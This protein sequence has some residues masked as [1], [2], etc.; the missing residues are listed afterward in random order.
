LD[1]SRYTHGP[2]LQEIDPDATL[3][4]H[5]GREFRIQGMTIG[6][7]QPGQHVVEDRDKGG[8]FQQVVE[9]Q[10]KSLRRGLESGR[11]RVVEIIVGQKGY[12]QV[13]V[14]I[15]STFE[16]LHEGFRDELI[17]RQIQKVY[18][19]LGILDDL[20]A[21]LWSQLGV[22]DG[23]HPRIVVTLPVNGPGSQ[24][25]DETDHAFRRIDAVGPG[26]KIP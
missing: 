9:S 12:E 20:H 22:A 10:N 26:V 5:K 13:E 1:G 8:F 14:G 7:L 4:G 25:E 6:P 15:V 21:E 2:A 11:Y 16:E 23:D 19:P 24:A 18:L 3:G 17:R